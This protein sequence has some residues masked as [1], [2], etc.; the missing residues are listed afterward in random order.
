MGAGASRAVVVIRG[1]IL[2]AA[3]VAAPSEMMTAMTVSARVG[4]RFAGVAAGPGAQTRSMTAPSPVRR[5]AV[6]DR[7]SRPVMTRSS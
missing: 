2:C 1:P 5:L 3:P 4:D 6:D 7:S